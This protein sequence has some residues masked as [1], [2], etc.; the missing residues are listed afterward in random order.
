MLSVHPYTVEEGTVIEDI[1]L[2][3][4]L[5]SFCSAIKALFIFDEN[6]TL[7]QKQPFQTQLRKLPLTEKLSGKT[8]F[9]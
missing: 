1:H 9:N 6:F 3:Y 8:T 4:P 2:R 7:V 5:Q